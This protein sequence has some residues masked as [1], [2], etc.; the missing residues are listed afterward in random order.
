[1]GCISIVNNVPDVDESF[2]LIV[3][4]CR[5]PDLA[6]DDRPV[7]G[8]CTGN[9]NEVFTETEVRE[10]V[11]G[12]LCCARPHPGFVGIPMLTGLDYLPFDRV[13][14]RGECF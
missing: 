3:V 6:K 2:A 8:R 14:H 5:Y 4:D 7:C 10:F 13:D 12:E 1:V 9:K 11:V